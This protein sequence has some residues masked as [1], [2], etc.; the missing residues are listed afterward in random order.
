MRLQLRRAQGPPGHPQTAA[1]KQRRCSR[2]V[3]P[4]RCP[5]HRRRRPSP[6]RH[7]TGRGSAASSRPHGAPPPQR[8]A[9]SGFPP[10][11]LAQAARDGST[12]PSPLRRSPRVSRCSWRRAPLQDLGA[13]PHRCDPCRGPPLPAPALAMLRCR[14]RRRHPLPPLPSPPPWPQYSLGPHPACQV[15]RS[16]HGGRIDWNL[17]AGR[18]GASATAQGHSPWKLQ[19]SP[20]TSRCR[21]PLPAPP[22]PQSS[23][24]AVP[25]RLPS[26][27]TRAL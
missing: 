26:L 12:T 27:R 14:H 17:P 16:W 24:A 1:K 3:A 7:C 11:G 13:H 4:R 22:P 6:Q 10:L 2:V 15:A 18:G 9:P 5:L 8:V 23:P 21:Q 25:T 20:V 19:G